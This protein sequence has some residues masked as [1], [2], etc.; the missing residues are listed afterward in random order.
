MVVRGARLAR[1]VL[2]LLL[3]V[4]ITDAPGNPR[5]H[6]EKLADAWFS[7]HNVPA[8]HIAAAPTLALYASGKTTGIVVDVGDGVS[9]VTPVYEGFAVP[10]AVTRSDIGGRDVTL[11]LIWHLRHSGRSFHTTAEAETVRLIKEAVCYV[12]QDPDAD[13]AAVRDGRFAGGSPAGATAAASAS[14]SAGAAAPTGGASAAG[15]AAV[16]AVS[17]SGVAEYVLPD[18]HRLSLGAERFRASEVLFR[19]SLLGLEYP[20][21]GEAVSTSVLKCD[22]ELRRTLLGNVVLAGGSTALPGFGSRLLKDVRKLTPADTHVKVWAAK[23]RK[24]LSWIGGSILASLSTFRGMCVTKRQWEEEGA[25]CITAASA[26][27]L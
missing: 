25:R 18:G 16:A 24:V 3:Q 4:L 22:L 20:G 15:P 13:E 9:S 17:T 12:S 10:S 11:Q 1:P 6:R 14:A 8:L 27:A 19:P 7:A 26:G 2:L 23:E 5:S 21:I